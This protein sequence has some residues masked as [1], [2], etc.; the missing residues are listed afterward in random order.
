MARGENTGT[1]QFPE[2]CSQNLARGNGDF[3]PQKKTKKNTSG[4]KGT[5]SASFEIPE[6]IQNLIMDITEY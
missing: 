1:W 2:H 4:N 3:L 5:S 6:R